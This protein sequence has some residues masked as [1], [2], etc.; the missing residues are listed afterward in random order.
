MFSCEFCEIFKNAFFQRTPLVTNRPFVNLGIGN[1]ALEL[2]L[3]LE[4]VL[5]TPLVPGLWAPNLA[6]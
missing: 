1:S 2:E 3:E 5:Q 6:G 4:L